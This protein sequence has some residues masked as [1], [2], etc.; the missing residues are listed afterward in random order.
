MCR[1]RPTILVVLAAVALAAPAAARTA[2]FLPRNLQ[3]TPDTSI[4]IEVSTNHIEYS[5]EYVNV[6]WSGVAVSRLVGA[7]VGG[8]GP[9]TA[10]SL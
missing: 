9:T 6:S 4:V 5:G 10:L 3:S 7:H 2:P 8:K 1:G